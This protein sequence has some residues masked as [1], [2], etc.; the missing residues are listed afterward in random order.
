MSLDEMLDT[1]ED[2]SGFEEMLDTLDVPASAIRNPTCVGRLARREPLALDELRFVRELQRHSSLVRVET[3]ATSAE[4]RE[5]PLIVIGDPPPSSPA[6]LRHDDPAI[7]HLEAKAEWTEFAVLAAGPEHAAVA[8]S[9]RH[10]HFDDHRP[11][12][13]GPGRAV[14]DGDERREG[15]DDPVPGADVDDPPLHPRRQAAPGLEGGGK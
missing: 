7:D 10:R 6:D 4:G 2:K 5:L 14:V 9:V 1:V 12:R 13:A 11:P 3:M 8:H 15:R